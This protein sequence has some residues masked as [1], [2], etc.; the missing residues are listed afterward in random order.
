ML[1]GAFMCFLQ[2]H[3]KRLLA[4]S[5]IS[6]AG[7]MLTGVALLDHKSLAGA[8]DLVVSHAFLKGGLFLVCGIVLRQLRHI[9]ELRLRGLG[10]ETPGVAVLWFAG[11]VGLVGFPYV[12]A[13][14]GHALVD[15]GAIAGNYAW[16]PPIAMVATGA[17][18]GAMLRAGARVFLGWGPGEDALLSEEPGEKAP[19]REASVTLM[20]TVTAL[21]VGI[22]LVASVV[23]GFVQRTESGAERFVDRGAYT[24]H[25][26]RGAPTSPSVRP[27][28][29][30]ASSTT[31]SVVYGAGALLVSIAV[32]ALGLWHRRLPRA[33]RS[34]AV[35]ALGRPVELLRA[36][37]SGIVGDYLLWIATGTV[38]VGGVWALTLI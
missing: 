16:L 12:G 32:A 25:V 26:L 29:A 24:A 3:L 13:F 6:H 5:T 21:M 23:P 19:P 31:S 28:V 2:Q 33:I 27:P 22:G 17:C 37:H 30:V 36:G 35:Q 7:L 34:G 4:Y 11:A 18:S 1:V 38:V 8:A 14:A 10:R 15:D 9:D 20:A